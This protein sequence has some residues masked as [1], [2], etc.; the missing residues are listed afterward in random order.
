MD[1][2]MPGAYNLVATSLRGSALVALSTIVLWRR[3]TG[4]VLE[5]Y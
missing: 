2:F 1:G 4:Q 3:S 5:A